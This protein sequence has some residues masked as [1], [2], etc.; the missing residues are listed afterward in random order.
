MFTFEYGCGQ[1]F[2]TLLHVNKDMCSGEFTLRVFPG[3]QSALPSHMGMDPQRL[4]S[5]LRLSK[6]Y[7]DQ[8]R[9]SGIWFSKNFS[10]YQCQMILKQNGYLLF[11][12]KFGTKIYQG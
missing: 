4:R 5:N 12:I 3:N 11:I 10:S 7:L 1:C 8:R 2:E 6:L 9:W